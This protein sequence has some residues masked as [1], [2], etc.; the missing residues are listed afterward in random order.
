MLDV[1]DMAQSSS[2]PHVVLQHA[3]LAKHVDVFASQHVTWTGTNS[4]SLFG[5]AWCWQGCSIAI[6]EGSHLLVKHLEESFD[7]SA[8]DRSEAQ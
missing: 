6:I 4:I 3:T 2:L 7:V 5:R 1:H 8:M